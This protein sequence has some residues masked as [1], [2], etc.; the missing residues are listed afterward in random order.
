MSQIGSFHKMQKSL[1]FRLANSASK[2]GASEGKNAETIISEKQA[3]EKIYLIGT[4]ILSDKKE[5]NYSSGF[6]QCLDRKGSEL[7]KQSYAVKGKDTYLYDMALLD[8]NTIGV[9]GQ[10][11]LDNEMGLFLAYDAGGNLKKTVK[12]QESVGLEKIRKS[13]DGSFVISGYDTEGNPVSYSVGSDFEM[14]KL[15]PTEKTDSSSELIQSVNAE[16]YDD[17]GNLYSAGESAEM[18][19][20]VACVVKSTKD[21]KNSVLYMATEPNS[22]IT[23]MKINRKTG[24]LLVCGSLSG[25]DEFGN[26]GKPFI[27]CLESKSGKIVWENILQKNKYEIAVKIVS[28][29]DYGFVVLLANADGDGNLASP[30]ALVRTNAVGKVEF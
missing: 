17:E 11:I 23:N 30:C 24:E 25:K 3:D 1:N 18:E 29:D 19:K 27:R 6:I 15:N 2:F 4:E 8:E 12:I 16:V 28:C 14:K 20:P 22:Y 10:I 5:N 21:K 26:G 9:V 13:A 7:W